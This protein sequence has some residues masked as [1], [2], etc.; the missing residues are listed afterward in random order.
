MRVDATAATEP[1]Y[2]SQPLFPGNDYRHES[3]SAAN[4]EEHLFPP[5]AGDVYSL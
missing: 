4:Q 1:A 3:Y 5:L 2:V